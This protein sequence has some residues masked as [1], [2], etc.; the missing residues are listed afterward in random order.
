MRA[1]LGILI[2]SFFLYLFLSPVNSLLAQEVAPKHND[3]QA[4][5]IDDLYIFM[6]SGAGSQYRLLGSITAGTQVTLLDEAQN[7]YQKI[8]DDK[9]R[10][11]WV[12]I[13]Y[14]QKTPGLRYV[15]AELNA[16]LADKDEQIQKLKSSLT[17]K[18]L[19]LNKL[20]SS[21]EQLSK[22]LQV[23]TKQLASAQQALD[24]QDTSTQKQWFFNGAIVLGIGLIL[25]LIL[26]RLG[27]RRRASMASWK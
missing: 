27:G 7:D 17:D 3:Q 26:P 15:I 6:R 21:T 1:L 12:E 4:Y 2:T 20:T 18:N 24:Q 22:R 14:L 19:Q 13:K 9:G 25:G 8:I 23:V 5:I 11:G 10:T 16:Q